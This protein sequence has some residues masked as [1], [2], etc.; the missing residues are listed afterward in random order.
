MYAPDTRN[1]LKIPEVSTAGV[2][3]S[4][5]GPCL[6]DPPLYSPSWKP[7]QNAKELKPSDVPEAAAPQKKKRK[8]WPFY[9]E[10]VRVLP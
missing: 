10:K 9:G 7:D 2:P 5:N 6:E 1:A 3:Y 4:K 8:W